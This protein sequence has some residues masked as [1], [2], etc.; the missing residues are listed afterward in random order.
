MYLIYGLGTSGVAAAK[1]L[2][3]QNTQFGVFQD[4]WADLSKPETQAKLSKL[5]INPDAFM[6]PDEAWSYIKTIVVSPGIPPSNK[7]VHRANE[8]GK[9]VITEVELGLRFLENIPWVGVTGTNGKSTVTSFVEQVAAKQGFRIPACGNIGVPVCQIALDVHQNQISKPNGLAIELSSYQ[10]HYLTAAY[11]LKGGAITSFAK[12]HTHWHGSFDNYKEAKARL[13]K[14]CISKNVPLFL[15]D[16]ASETFAR[17]ADSKHLQQTLDGSLNMQELNVE[18]AKE[19]AYTITQTPAE[20]CFANLRQL[21]FRWQPLCSDSKIINDSKSTNMQSL[22]FGVKKLFE[23]IDSNRN[24]SILVG[25]QGKKDGYSEAF[26]NLA[27]LAA[28]KRIKTSWVCFGQS[29]SDLFK[30]IPTSTN[31]ATYNQKSQFKTLASAVRHALAERKNSDYILFSPGCASF[32]EFKNFSQ[33]GAK[34]EEL[35]LGFYEKSS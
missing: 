1:L 28:E 32:D 6:H 16:Q 26:Q 27:E 33:R 17:E 8:E 3:Y 5:S 9:K 2:E 23:C 7:W 22:A 35:V 21:P 15:S 19:L 13:I 31:L 10:L 30:A 25:G 18:L 11:T 12:D 34:F 24:V 14:F 4:N 29:G 20:Q